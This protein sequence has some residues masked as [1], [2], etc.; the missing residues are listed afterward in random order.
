MTWLAD[1]IAVAALVLGAWLR[2]AGS[3]TSQIARA[4]AHHD[5][6]EGVPGARGLAALLDDRPRILPAVGVVCSA[7][8]V[9][10]AALLVVGRSADL[11]AGEAAALTVAVV[12]LGDVVPRLLGRARPTAAAYRSAPLLTAAV[13]VAGWAA[14][15]SVEDH[16]NGNGEQAEEEDDDED[17]I[18]LIS[19]VLR[20]S[21]T[22]VREVMVPRPDMV[23]VADSAGAEELAAAA[24]EHGYSRFPVVSGDDVVGIVLVKDLF[25][26]LNGHRSDVTATTVM[27]P[28]AFV[29]EMKQIADLLAEMRASKNHMEI[30]VDEFGDIAGLV[31]IEDL[32]EELVGEIAD[33]TDDDETWVE[34]LAE[35][36]WRVDARLP[37]EDLAELLD[38]ALPEGDWDTVGGL[39]LGL[40][41]RV[42][43]ESESFEM[44]VASLV[45]DRMQGRR[46]SQVIVRARASTDVNS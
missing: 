25:P 32:L 7:L 2:A 3:A 9:L 24:I 23:T 26:Y 17:E 36:E 20:F 15:S 10:A 37:V 22:I 40:A 35:G 38:S 45:V 33:E 41:E 1:V 30:V 31:T 18:A 39:V 46:V 27:R 44:S 43:A 14:D 19:S 28:A 5:A 12:T 13:K 29:P 4:D 16:Q 6:A 42:P 21:E 34:P 8:L 11:S